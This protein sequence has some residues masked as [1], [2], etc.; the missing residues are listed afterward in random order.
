MIENKRIS[1]NVERNKQIISI[2][3]TVTEDKKKVAKKWVLKMSTEEL[4][5]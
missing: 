3:F 2:N 1:S 5:K 4:A